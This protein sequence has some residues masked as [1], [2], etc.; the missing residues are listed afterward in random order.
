MSNAKAIAAAF[1]AVLSWVAASYTD[2]PWTGHLTV[3]LAIQVLTAIGV[4]VIPNTGNQPWA[5]CL[6]AI[7][8]AMLLVLS[9]SLDG[10]VSTPELLQILLAGFAA[11]GVGTAANSVKQRRSTHDGLRSA[12]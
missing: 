10:G 7:G 11:A 2:G 5:K 3:N 9:S 12:A 8:G 4:Y 6:V 1:A